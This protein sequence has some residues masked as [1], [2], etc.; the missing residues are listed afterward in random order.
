MNENDNQP[1]G[2]PQ[3]IEPAEGRKFFKRV[4]G[5][6]MIVAGGFVAF[7]TLLAPTRLSGASRSARLQWQQRQKE[8]RETIEHDPCGS[9]ESHK[10]AD[11]NTGASLKP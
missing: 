1:I 4:A 7:A 10:S 6:V 3:P 9:T 5:A 11:S 2:E 8:I